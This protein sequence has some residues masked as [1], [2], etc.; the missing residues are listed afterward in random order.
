MG[1]TCSTTFCYDRAFLSPKT[2]AR[3]KMTVIHNTLQHS[4][5]KYRDPLCQLVG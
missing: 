1:S 4:S 3:L 2:E 5:I